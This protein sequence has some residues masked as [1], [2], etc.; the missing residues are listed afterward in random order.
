MIAGIADTHAALWY[1][2]GNPRLSQATKETFEGAANG[3]Q[4]IAVSVISLAEL[5]YLVEKNRL[6]ASAYSD[7]QAALRD[8][9][10]VLEEAPV[11]MEIVNAMMA[12]PRSDNRTCPTGS[13]RRRHVISRFR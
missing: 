1:V 12:V 13:S 4:K 5:V 10:H 7:L 6:P 9:D 2:F 11:T 3:R 8:P